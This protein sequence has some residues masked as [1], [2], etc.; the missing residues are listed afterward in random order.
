MQISSFPA[1]GWV[2]LWEHGDLAD[3][4]DDKVECCQEKSVL[5]EASAANKGTC[6]VIYGMAKKR[7]YQ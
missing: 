1:C 2:G 3:T 7:A 5:A 6:G 4:E